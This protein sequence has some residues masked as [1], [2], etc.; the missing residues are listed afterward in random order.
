MYARL[1]S[2]D[3]FAI[4]MSF[5]FLLGISVRFEQEA[6]PIMGKRKQV[7]DPRQHGCFVI[8]LD[9]LL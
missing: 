2:Y 9:S 4:L 3:R 6:Q 1:Y 8:K 7:H 5:T